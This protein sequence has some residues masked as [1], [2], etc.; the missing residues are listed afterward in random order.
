VIDG[1]LEATTIPNPGPD[2]WGADFAV[3]V[4]A[5][6]VPA[7]IAGSR[8]RPGRVGTIRRRRA[9]EPTSDQAA[10][11]APFE[12]QKSFSAPCTVVMYL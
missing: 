2:G 4:P 9:G 6:F 8:S 12:T 5:D 7:T 10:G 1:R 3:R 11:A